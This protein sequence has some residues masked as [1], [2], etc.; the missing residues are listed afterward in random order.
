MPD[1]MQNQ[2][3]TPAVASSRYLG[4]AGEEYFAYLRQGGLVRGEL[5]A[6][7]KFARFVKPSDVVLDFGCGEG[8]LLRAFQCARRLGVEVNPVARA[9]AKTNGVEVFETLAEIPA[10]SVDLAVSNHALEHVFSP[11]QIL[12]D[13]ATKLKLGG[14]LVLVVPIDDWR[15]QRT[16]NPKDLDH[17]LYTWTPLLLGNLLVEAGYQVHDI[18]VLT[19]AWFPGWDRWI[20][21][22]PTWLFDAV[23]WGY[24]AYSRR[25]QLVA[26]A[27]PARGG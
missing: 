23:C 15:V 3:E 11:V 22:L 21:R 26:V 4:K 10:G 2:V 17:H 13:L 16:F 9:Q 27:E 25:R 24:S 7:T 8:T 14:K 18:S 1:P 5:N 19:H 6:R 12:R 20:G